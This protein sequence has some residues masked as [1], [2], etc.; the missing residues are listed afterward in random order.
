MTILWAILNSGYFE[1]KC[2]KKN[3][4]SISNFIIIGLDIRTIKCAKIS[5]LNERST[6]IQQ[7]LEMMITQKKTSGVALTQL[8][9]NLHYSRR[10]LHNQL[11]IY[12]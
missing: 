12:I 8:S 7:S 3:I 4:Y 5:P 2:N 9:L 1:A 11:Y 10:V 6:F